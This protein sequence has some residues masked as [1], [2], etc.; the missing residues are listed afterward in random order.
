MPGGEWPAADPDVKNPKQKG[1]PKGS[2][3]KTRESII[4]EVEAALEEGVSWREFSRAS[5]PERFLNDQEL[6]MYRGQFAGDLR[7]AV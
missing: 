2:A 5:H 4:E 7:V 3:R 1:R 6:E